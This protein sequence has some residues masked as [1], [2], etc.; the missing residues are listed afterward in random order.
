[1]AIASFLILF[2]SVPC[3]LFPV[4]ESVKFSFSILS[5][6]EPKNLKKLSRFQRSLS[7]CQKGSKRREKARLRVAKLHAKIKDI[8][9]DFLH[10]LSTRL[11]REN[12]TVILEDLNV[13]VTI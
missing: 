12:Q 5:T 6:E 13:S 3:S 7:R 11:T 9:K 10:K 2:L 4:P 8:R 1:M